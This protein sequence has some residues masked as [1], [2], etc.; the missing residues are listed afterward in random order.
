VTGG[1]SGPAGS[2][3]DLTVV[4]PAYNEPG[5]ERVVREVVALVDDLVPGRGEVVVVDD[6]S[7]DDTPVTLG[8]L[9]TELP[10]L[11]V[12]RQPVNQGH[13]PALIRGF[14]A[15]RGAWIG[16]LDTDDQIPTAELGRLWG[17]RDG[18][19]LVLG[20][21]VQRHDPR[22]RL[23]LTAF[24]R[25]LVGRLA[26]SPVHDANVPCKIFTRELWAEVAPLVPAD[27]FAPSLALVVVAYRRERTVRI[28]EVRHQPRMEGE[29]TLRPARLAR[30]V[31]RSTR[32]TVAVARRC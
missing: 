26:G 30:A 5:I 21:R 3:V 24:T 2:P 22:H 12:L 18:A 29:T 25:T 6:A 1:A 19:D 23:V 4:L 17:E 9:A 8:R 14:G 16:H 11:T 27:T 32:Q 31:A 7:T 10:T 20:S 13:G 28:L 15:A